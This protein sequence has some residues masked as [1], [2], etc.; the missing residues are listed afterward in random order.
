MQKTY[1]DTWAEVDLG[2]I[3]HNVEAVR[4]RIGTKV[5]L[6][7]VVKANAY[8][9]GA[10]PV[11]T[12]ALAS[13]ANALA[14]AT[15]DEALALRQA[16]IQAP[17]LVF[18]YVNPEYLAVAAENRIILTVISVDHARA[19]AA[20]DGQLQASTA[21]QVHLKLDTGMSRIGVQSVTELEQAVAA[22]AG[23]RG[24]IVGAYTHL[25]R[26]DELDKT[27]ARQQ[28][29]LARVWF[30]RLRE[31]VPNPAQ[32]TLHAANSAAVL[33]LADSYF[34][35]VRLGISLYGVYPSAQVDRSAVYLRQ[36]LRLYTRVVHLK[37]VPP[38]TPV[39]YGGTFVTA[40][41]TRLATLPIGYADGLMLKL[42]NRG[43]VTLANR[44]CPIVGR[45]CMDQTLV[46]VTALPGVQV[47]DRVTLYDSDSLNELAELAETI[48]YV[49]LCAISERVP[50][51]YTGGL[52]R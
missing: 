21:Y 32:L 35:M 5:K 16:D 39:S 28:L 13:G 49:L 47:G 18:G 23:T 45:I 11:A 36:A 33:D 12:T 27:S 7:A 6:M 40:Q 2:A 10:I 24:R 51:V 17:I 43:F 22:L 50:R 31:I 34:S 46:D 42:S 41:T 8:G 20:Q 1:R 26:A 19:L 4:Q 3:A 37:Q 29:A 38:G 9:H 44:R 52:S 15:L 48:P 30:Q 25:A 14:V